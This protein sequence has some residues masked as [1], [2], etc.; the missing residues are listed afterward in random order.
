MYVYIGDLKLLSGAH[1]AE[2]DRQDE[3]VAISQLHLQ[4][5]FAVFQD[6]WNGIEAGRRGSVVRVWRWILFFLGQL[7]HNEVVDA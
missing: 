6:A 5:V 4:R 2:L 7:G 1:G 3:F